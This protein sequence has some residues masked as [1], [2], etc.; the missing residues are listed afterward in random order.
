MSIYSD[1]RTLL[2]SIRLWLSLAVAIMI[3]TIGSAGVLP[4]GLEFGMSQAQAEERLAGNCATSG[5]VAVS[6]PSFPLARDREVH[7]ICQSFSLGGLKF[8]VLALT[9]ADDR[10]E[11]LYAEGN[12]ASLAEAASAS[13]QPYLQYQASFEDLLVIEP[14][15]E[16]AWIMSEK[17]AHPNLFAWPNPYVESGFSAQYLS[18]A[19]QPEILAFGKTLDELKPLYESQCNFMHLDQYRVWLLNKPEEQ[20]QIDCFGFEFAGFPRKIEAV[21][22]DGILEQAWILTGQGEED[23]VRQALVRSYG[24]PVYVDADW[25]IFGDGAVVLRKDKPEVLMLS[26]KLAPLFRAEYI[27]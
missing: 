12:V 3:P 19:D 27:D 2:G 6:P 23:R 13:L 9:F 17:A 4:A 7:L 24:E 18:S 5:K 22:G 15:A 8:G 11:L 14:G 20:H 16:R 26:E 1:I 21:F 10:L 25:E